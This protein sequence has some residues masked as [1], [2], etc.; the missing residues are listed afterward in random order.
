MVALVVREVE[1]GIDAVRRRSEYETIRARAAGDQVVA[2]TADQNIV[3]VT[4]VDGVVAT[5]ADRGLD[6]GVEGDAD[7]VGEAVASAEASGV[8]IDDRRSRPAGEIQGVVHPAV[9][10]RDDGLGVL[11]E[12][13][14]RL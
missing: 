5:A 6:H 8:E 14:V 3:V 9:P 2:G 13:E 12:I 4:A 11:V 10:D 7:I 1:K